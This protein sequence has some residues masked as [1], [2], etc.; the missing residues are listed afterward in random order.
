VF[1]TDPD[2]T[3]SNSGNYWRS[4]WG[5]VQ[6]PSSTDGSQTD[7][8]SFTIIPDDTDDK[9]WLRPSPWGEQSDVPLPPDS[10]VPVAPDKGDNTSDHTKPGDNEGS[11]TRD[12]V[13]KSLQDDQETR[14]ESSFETAVA[15]CK[16]LGKQ[17][18]VALES[19]MKDWLAPSSKDL[20]TSMRGIAA[21]ADGIGE[22]R[23][24]EGSRIDPKSH[25]D[26]KPR[27]LKGYDYDFGGEATSFLRMAVGELVQ[28]QQYV[29][30]HKGHVF[31]G[32]P[33]DD[34]YIQQ[35]HNLQTD[36][37][38]KLNIVYGKH[39]VDSIYKVLQHEIRYHPEDW[40]KGLVRMRQTLDDLKTTDQRFLA[41]SARD[42]ALG[43]L[44][45]AAYMASQDNGEDAKIVYQDA[46]K[47][48]RMSMKN[49]A[50]APDNLAIQNISTQLAPH[51][52]QA[53]DNNWKDPFDNPF[54]IPIPKDDHV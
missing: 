39:D 8:S 40:Q 18:E 44:S 2:Q 4:D 45:E 23:L 46:N 35:L 24:E 27:I 51:I 49:D 13:D 7:H 6:P 30:G 10:N 34:A 19:L 42:L 22:F 20:L 50:S 32:Q 5:E 47:Y 25:Q 38:D 36:V 21:V 52:N 3:G 15:Q 48:L 12:A 37:E 16:A 9:F 17:D 26:T 29:N 1:P 53:I 33:M 14:S 31:E 41:K 43:Y 11:I 54:N 28:A